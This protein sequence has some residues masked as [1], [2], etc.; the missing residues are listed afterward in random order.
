MPANYLHI[1]PR[2]QYMMIA[3]PNQDKSWTVTLFM[4]FEIFN[5][6][7]TPETLLD[8][9]KVRGWMEN[10]RP[11]VIFFLFISFKGYM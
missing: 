1:W 11:L 3:L 10:W 7:D 4:P 9:F 6:L 2:G 5:S 8:F